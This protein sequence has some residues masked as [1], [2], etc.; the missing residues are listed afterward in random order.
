MSSR[1][2]QK[3]SVKKISVV[4]F[5]SNGKCYWLRESGYIEQYCYDYGTKHINK[6]KNNKKS[7]NNKK[8]EK[9]GDDD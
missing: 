6:L 5:L 9:N 8:F 7:E 2:K 1:H 4:F 3:R